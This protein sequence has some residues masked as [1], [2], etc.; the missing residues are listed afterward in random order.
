M[1]LFAFFYPFFG[2]GLVTYFI[3]AIVAFAR[4]KRDAVSI[5][6]LNFFLGW[7][8]IGWVIALVWALK[9]DVPAVVR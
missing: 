8:A 2:F 3:P 1:H 7:T 4:N 9:T 5:L 6:V